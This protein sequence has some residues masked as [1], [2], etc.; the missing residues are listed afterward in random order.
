MALMATRTRLSRLLLCSL[1]GKSRVAP[2]SVSTSIGSD[3]LGYCDYSRSRH[4]SS[5]SALAVSEP[6]AASSRHIGLEMLAV[7]DYLD[8]RRSLYGEITHKALFVDAVGTLLAPS[9]PMA[10]IYR[11]IERVWE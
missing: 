10:Q 1:S 8:Y 3:P 2:R 4:F 5:S 7:K 11:E 6:D 9:Q